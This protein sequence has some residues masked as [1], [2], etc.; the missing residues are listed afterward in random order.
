[1]NP[2]KSQHATPCTQ[3]NGYWSKPLFCLCAGVYDM[4]RCCSEWTTAHRERLERWRRED[5]R[6]I[7]SGIQLL[8]RATATESNSFSVLRFEFLQILHVFL[9]IFLRRNVIH[10]S[11]IGSDLPDQA[12]DYHQIWQLSIHASGVGA[13][14]RAI[15]SSS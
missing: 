12:I 5:P 11:M 4:R 15:A 10:L 7:L 6:L 3:H 8:G 1:M 13:S 14:R 9:L 2:P